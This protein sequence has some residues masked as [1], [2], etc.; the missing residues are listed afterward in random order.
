M[1]NTE[2]CYKTHLQVSEDMA[3]TL[4]ETQE[5]RNQLS[6]LSRSVKVMA[7]RGRGSPV[8]NRQKRRE[9]DGMA[10]FV[11]GSQSM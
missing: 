2:T 9:T 6:D 1:K 4:K 5:I 10:S 3:I 11:L 8:S 7:K